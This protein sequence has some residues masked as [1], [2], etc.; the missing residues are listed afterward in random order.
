MGSSFCY[1]TIPRCKLTE[2]RRQ[3]LRKEWEAFIPDMLLNDPVE[4]FE[5]EATRRMDQFF[6]EYFVV[7]VGEH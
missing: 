7:L 1:T 6:E 5:E 4:D 3:F 2:E